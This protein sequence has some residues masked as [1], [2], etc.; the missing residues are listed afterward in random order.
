MFV[1][2]KRTA[3]SLLKEAKKQI[4]DSEKTTQNVGPLPPKNTDVKINENKRNRGVPNYVKFTPSEFMSWWIASTGAKRKA[5]NILLHY[6]KFKFNAQIPTDY[7]TLLRTPVNPVPFLMHPGSYIHVGVHRAL[8]HLLSEVRDIQSMFTDAKVLMQFFVDGIR[9]TKST[10]ADAWVIM[11]S[12]RRKVKKRLRLV[13]KV[14]GVYYGDKKPEDFNQFLWPFV[15][16]LL[17]LIDTGIEFNNVQLKL[18]ILNFVMDAPARC[19]CKQITG[20]NGYFG[21]DNC[22]EEGDYIEHR[23][24]FLNM[25]APERND[26]D[27]RNR[28][29]DDQDYHKMESV[30]ELL[31]IDMIESFPLDYLHVLLVGVEKWLLEFTLYAP[32]SLSVRDH[33]VIKERVMSFR[34]TQPKEFQRNLRSFVEDLS[35]MK[36]TEF[37]TYVLFVGPLLLRG[38]ISEEKISNLLKLQIASIIFTHERFN[39]YYEEADKLMRMFVEE[40]ADL[41]HP[42]HGT[43]VFHSLCHMKKYVDI[44]GAWD[45][46]STFEFES[47]NSKVKDMLHGNVM[48]LTQITNRIIEIYQSTKNNFGNE[49]HIAEVKDRQEDGTFLQL[50]YHD[51]H[52]NRA[53]E[54][55]NYI[56]LKSGVSVKLISIFEDEVT[57]EIGLIGASLQNCSSVFSNIVDTTRFNVFK[58][59]L[60]FGSNIKFSIKD[61]DG[62]LWKMDIPNSLESAFYPIYVEDA[63][64]FNY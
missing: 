51:L 41:Y 19:Y 30:L 6:M 13:P 12:I 22:V 37:R 36:G 15:M 59:K 28:V 52:F 7:R 24:T 21:C 58:C 27:Y 11:M 43:Y 18:E 57:S 4:I 55:Q 54:G 8:Y 2:K 17:D 26:A 40:F 31:P 3:S 35:Y 20:V 50:I 9:M 56:L 1:I 49:S 61:I 14:I 32:K 33:E 10:K 53:L 44:Y 63:K 42:R 38:I 62:K 45:N 46:F 47:Y 16:E 29:Y 25:N 5:S 60:D 48:P 64:S 39:Q 34:S 23:M